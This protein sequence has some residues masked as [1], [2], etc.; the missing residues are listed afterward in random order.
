MISVKKLSGGGDVAVEK[1]IE[2]AS[3][4]GVDLIEVRWVTKNNLPRWSVAQING[5]KV[6]NMNGISFEDDNAHV[7]SWIDSTLKFYPD[8]NGRCWG[9][10]YDTPENREY[11]Y[12]SISNNWF[13]VVDKKVREEVFNEAKE[14]GFNTDVVNKNEVSIK[15]T[16]RERDAINKTKLLEKQLED[17]E[18]QK[19]ALE[20][21]YLVAK[22][23]KSVITEKKIKGI[24]IDIDNT[25]VNEE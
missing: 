25:T 11:I 1:M 13:V 3:L 6:P 8:A 21:K 12:S 22:G 2:N 18:R 14:H 7:S 9:Y 4:V 15:I 24:K 16:T 5:F 23:E 10:I 20:D 17:L 19:K